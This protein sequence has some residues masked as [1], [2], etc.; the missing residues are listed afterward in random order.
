[1]KDIKRSMLKT[2]IKPDKDRLWKN[3][4]PFLPDNEPY[5]E[6]NRKSLLK[7]LAGLPV[8]Y[9]ERNVWENI[10]NRIPYGYTPKLKIYF[11]YAAGIAASILI[12]LALQTVFFQKPFINKSANTITNNANTDIET[13]LANL[14]VNNPQKCKTPDFLELKNEILTLQGQKLEIHDQVFYNTDDQNIK[15]TI[16]KIDAQIVSLK[17]QIE[18]YVSL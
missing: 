2:T 10:V 6:M 7:G 3:I 17:K 8:I 9:P 15:N 4:E 11:K 14:C 13:F 16:H 18:V 12:L 5:L 1:M